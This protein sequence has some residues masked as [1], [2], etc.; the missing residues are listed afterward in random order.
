MAEKPNDPSKDPKVVDAVGYGFDASV[1]KGTKAGAAAMEKHMVGLTEYQKLWARS[2]F[3][4]KVAKQTILNDPERIKKGEEQVKIYRKAFPTN[5]SI[6][7]LEQF[8]PA[9]EEL[10]KQKAD[11]NDS[12]PSPPKPAP[13]IIKKTPTK[14][15]KLKII[16]IP[17][18][19][20]TVTAKGTKVPTKSAVKPST[21]K[22]I[23]TGDTKKNYPGD[24]NYNPFNKK[25]LEQLETSRKKAA[26]V[27][28]SKLLGIK[29]GRK[30]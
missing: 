24:M 30:K 13:K 25:G 14:V 15:P 12:M 18:P 1:R 29:V 21:G 10:N 5:K 23:I 26:K 28:M 7:Y 2:T 9:T 4:E 22:V 27:P 20:K 19:K 16:T 8:D 17:S 6:N 11:A 3:N